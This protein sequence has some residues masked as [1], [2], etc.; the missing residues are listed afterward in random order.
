MDETK[1]EEFTKDIKNRICSGKAHPIYIQAN[2][3]ISHIQP[4]CNQPPQSVD[5]YK[6]T[7]QIST[8]YAIPTLQTTHHHENE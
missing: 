5:Q 7:A 3:K 4:N 8:T 2:K 1:W 6:Q